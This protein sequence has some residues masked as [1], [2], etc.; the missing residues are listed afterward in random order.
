L[1]R[2]ISLPKIERLARGKQQAASE[3]L[4]TDCG[5]AAKTRFDLKISHPPKVACVRENSKMAAKWAGES[6]KSPRVFGQQRKFSEKF[7]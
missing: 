6:T 3:E 1:A 5:G 2:A 4:G 7:G